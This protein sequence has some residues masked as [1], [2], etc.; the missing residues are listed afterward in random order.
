MT[1]GPQPL[2]ND[3]DQPAD[4]TSVGK[5]DAGELADLLEQARDAALE[6]DWTGV[7]DRLDSALDSLDPVDNESVGKWWSG[8]TLASSTWLVAAGIAI[9]IIG[10]ILWFRAGIG[11]ENISD[12]L[13]V[14][15][16]FTND[17]NRMKTILSLE[18]DRLTRQI[19][20][21]VGIGVVIAG[22]LT[23]IYAYTRPRR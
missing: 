6:E 2:D 7:R 15:E 18:D 12:D 4:G 8:R 23:T 14:I 19:T 11:L 20:Q 17:A 21:A 3:T 5:P 22:A 10:G 13:R 1:P 9:M 16:T